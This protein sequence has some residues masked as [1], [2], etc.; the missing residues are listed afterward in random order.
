MR[1]RKSSATAG[2]WDYSYRHAYDTVAHSMMKCAE[3]YINDR[4]LSEL[5]DT[6]E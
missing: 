3:S 1:R 6:N 2:L 4:F 5:V